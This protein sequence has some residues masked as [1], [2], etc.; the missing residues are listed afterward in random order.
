MIF[1]FHK[2]CH[3]GFFVSLACLGREKQIRYTDIHIIHFNNNNLCMKIVH[4]FTT[5]LINLAYF[6]S[7]T[8]V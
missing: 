2:N 8:F 3:P 5:C 1:N 6:T 7:G 4:L